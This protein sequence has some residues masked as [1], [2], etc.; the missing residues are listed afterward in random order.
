MS[1]END[2]KIRNSQEIPP[3]KD[4]DLAAENGRLKDKIKDME[5]GLKNGEKIAGEQI[6]TLRKT[7]NTRE[8]ANFGLIL[9]FGAT[10][11]G[12]LGWFSYLSAG[13]HY[14][15]KLANDESDAC[16]LVETQR[17]R[18]EAEVRAISVIH[19]EDGYISTQDLL[20]QLN[21][22][23]RP[24]HDQIEKLEAEKAELEK[25]LK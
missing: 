24:L 11:L 16:K 10:L 19:T 22:A 6:A 13:N 18:A 14:F 3:D 23:T 4:F 20:H 9:A 7:L 21:G 2:P 17:D 8:S 12:L 25:K 1:D 15:E 5:A